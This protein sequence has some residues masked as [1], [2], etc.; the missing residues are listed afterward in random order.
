MNVSQSTECILH[1]LLISR[2]NDVRGRRCRDRTP[3]VAARRRTKGTGRSSRPRARGG[4]HVA[5]SCVRAAMTRGDEHQPLLTPASEGSNRK[6]SGASASRLA[7]ACGRIARI[8]DRDK[9]VI[10]PE[11]ILAGPSTRVP[12]GKNAFRRP[13]A[14]PLE[15]PGMRGVHTTVWLPSRRRLFEGRGTETGPFFFI[16]IVARRNRLYARPSRRAEKHHMTD[17]RRISSSPRLLVLVAFLSRTQKKKALSSLSRR[18]SP[19]APRRA[20]RAPRF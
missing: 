19:W 4:V 17:L 5:Q 10:D 20:S 14:C 9:R 6:K 7:G 16:F 18:F 3:S 12:L 13:R 2:R 1:R 11:G 15:P 8:P